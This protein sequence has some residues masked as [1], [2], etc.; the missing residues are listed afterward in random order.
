LR[1]L[2]DAG[3]SDVTKIT[4]ARDMVNQ[5]WFQH[6]INSSRPVDMFLVLG[7]NPVRSSIGGIFSVILDAI[8]QAHP[9]TPIQIFGGHTHIRDFA[10]LDDSSTALESGQASLFV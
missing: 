7:H 6:A 4:K 2:N 8:R 1:K 10:V 9:R 5:D 3:N